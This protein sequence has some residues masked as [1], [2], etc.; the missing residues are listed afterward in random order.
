MKVLIIE[1]EKKLGKLIKKGLEEESFIVDLVHTGKE[2]L[3]FLTTQSYDA[4]ILDLMLPDIS[5]KDV[6][7]K[8]RNSSI[9]TPVIVLT[10]KDEVKDKIELLDAGADDY[11]TKP[12]D[13]DELLARIRAVVRRDK[14][15][16]SSVI[17][18][19]DLEI[20][21]SK[22]TVKKS[23]NLIK[24]SSKEY[25]LL[26]YFIFNRGKIL[27]KDNLINAVYDLS[28][29]LNSNALEV[30]ISRLRSKIEDE[31]HKYIKSI[32]GLGYIFD[33]E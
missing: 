6:L 28:F 11:I 5:G 2:A 26:R 19:G 17:S 25:L 8:I 10:A 14:D 15:I 27:T 13:F 4:I 16:K 31:N 23:G 3:D 9:K 20:D 32:R 33:E 22:S 12:F 18:I 30:L 7:I 21:L 29:E 1:D 24:L